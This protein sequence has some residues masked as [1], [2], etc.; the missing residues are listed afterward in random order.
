MSALDL[1][2]MLVFDPELGSELCRKS[3]ENWNSCGGGVRGQ[4]ITL[5]RSFLCLNGTAVLKAGHTFRENT[6]LSLANLVQPARM[7]AVRI[8]RWQVCVFTCVFPP[9]S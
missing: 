2:G 3:L 4:I 8:P 7:M 6:A 5:R 9:V 1:M